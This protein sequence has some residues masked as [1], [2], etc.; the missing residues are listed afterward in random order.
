MQILVLAGFISSIGSLTSPVFR[1]IGKPK[2]NTICQIARMAVLFATIYP[3]SLRWGIVGTSLA[4]FAGYFISSIAYC[5]MA[6]KITRCKVLSFSKIVA[7]PII[8]TVFMVLIVFFLKSSFQIIGV[9]QFF[10]LVATGII[11][12]LFSIYLCDRCLNYGIQKLVKEDLLFRK[13]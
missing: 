6:I 7:V 9:F 11:S 3:F 1:G 10:L 8:C 13:H 2:I 4:V 12:F 5:F